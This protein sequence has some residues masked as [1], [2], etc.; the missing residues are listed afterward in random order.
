[1]AKGNK[2]PVLPMAEE[3]HHVSVTFNGVLY[4]IPLSIG[5]AI[6]AQKLIGKDVLANLAKGLI[7]IDTLI[8]FITAGLRRVGGEA[9]N[10][11]TVDEVMD[12]ITAQELPGLLKTF[13]V[14][15]APD[16]AP[17]TSAEGNAEAEKPGPGSESEG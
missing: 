3:M 13:G 8:G 9:L 15:M 7:D 14:R 1:M 6:Q 4:D 5:F 2:K 11:L 12:G 16:I 17:D 10:E